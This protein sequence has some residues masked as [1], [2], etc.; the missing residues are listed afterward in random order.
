MSKQSQDLIETETSDVERSKIELQQYIQNIRSVLTRRRLEQFG[1]ATRSAKKEID[2]K[3]MAAENP[4]LSLSLTLKHLHNRYASCIEQQRWDDCLQ[5]I[6]D[7]VREK[8]INIHG[9]CRRIALEAAIYFS[10]FN[11]HINWD[12]PTPNDIIPEW[13]VPQ[14]LYLWWQVAKDSS[15]EICQRSPLFTRQKI[16]LNALISTIRAN[17]TN[18]ENNLPAGRILFKTRFFELFTSEITPVLS[19]S[20]RP[21]INSYPDSSNVI[22]SMIYFHGIGTIIDQK[23]AFECYSLAASQ[24]NLYAQQLMGEFCFRVNE[25]LKQRQQLESSH[26]KC[27]QKQRQRLESSHKKCLQNQRPCGLE[28][29]ASGSSIQDEQLKKQTEQMK[30]QIILLGMSQWDTELSYGVNN[31][32]YETAGTQWFLLAATQGH[33]L[34]QL[35]LSTCFA[36]GRGVLKDTQET[37][38]WHRRAALQGNV[39]AQFNLAIRYFNGYGVLKDKKI[40]FEWLQKAMAQEHPDAKNILEAEA[41]QGDPHA[42]YYLSHCYANGIGM[43]RDERQAVDWCRKAAEQEHTVAQLNLASWNFNGLFVSK[44][45]KVAAEWYRR[46]ANNGNAEAQFQLGECYANGIGVLR[47]VRQAVDWYRRAS[48]QEHDRAQNSLGYYYANGIGVPKDTSA[49]VCLFSRAARQ[50]FAAAQSNLGQCYLR[51]VGVTQDNTIASHWLQRAAEQGYIPC[52]SSQ[53]Y[54]F[55]L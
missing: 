50:G 5:E 43:L 11:R 55:N 22:F 10:H 1:I 31:V 29:S 3:T 51:G 20:T 46:A 18:E 21:I 27:L 33:P 6:V 54:L 48:M 44:D 13:S 12:T 47:D 42:Q 39:Q 37:I 32:N 23:R 4:L 38:K 53:S 15:P 26:K 30:R 36:T 14:M 40:A 41:E 28:S 9:N 34:A 7:F 49:A 2:E 25:K 17:N 24:G 35:T 19:A 45:V 8:T 16:F 52:F